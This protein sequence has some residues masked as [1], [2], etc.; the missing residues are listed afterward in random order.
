MLSADFV[1]SAEPGLFTTGA[2]FELGW[3]VGDVPIVLGAVVEEEDEEDDEPVPI[4]VSVLC[5]PLVVVLVGVVVVVVAGVDGSLLVV[6]VLL[7]S[8]GDDV[9][10]E[11]SRAP[12]RLSPP[13]AAV[14]SAD[15]ASAPRKKVERV[16]FVMD[17]P[18][19]VRYVGE[20]R[21]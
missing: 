19:S 5:S 3:G 13:H 12:W 2:S 20:A 8:Y 6:I 16:M 9:P 10:V 17:Q 11:G 1:W 14:V 15:S 21:P 18:A 7:L 4:V